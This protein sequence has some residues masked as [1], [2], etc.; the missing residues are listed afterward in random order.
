M[1]MMLAIC[2]LFTSVHSFANNSYYPISSIVKFQDINT[3]SSELKNEI[4]DLSDKFHI[5]QTDGSQILADICNAT[6][7]CNSQR[8]DQTYN[9]ARKIMFGQLFLE[10]IGSHK[11]AVKDVYCNITIDETK[12]AGPNK[13][14]NSK[15]IN[16]EH[17]WPQS[18]FTKDFS[19]ELQKSDLH[20]LFPSDMRANTIRSNRPFADVDGKITH[21]ECIDSKTG[22]ARVS[23]VRSF[24]PPSEHKGNVARAIYYF[25][26]R[27]RMKIDAVQA[28]YLKAWNEEDPVDLE[29]LERN[30]SI[31]KLQGNR[32]P[33][34][35]FPELINRL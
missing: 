26:T 24:E 1:R 30:D 25:S 20:H 17:T 32:N 7:T 29:E 9:E 16:C 34:I 35:D 13:I 19:N 4:F 6:E 2:M 31:M 23:T 5:I 10:N 28:R 11:Y 15:F 21:N 33:F 27:Y 22:S 12:G 18:K 3:T 14:P 8:R